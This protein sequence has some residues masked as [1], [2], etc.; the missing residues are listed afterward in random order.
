MTSSIGVQPK[1]LTRR[2]GPVGEI[3]LN[4]P[5]RLN[6]ITVDMW[7]RL[8]EVLAEA[9]ADGA[10]RVLLISGAGGKAFA[11]GADISTIS[12]E[13]GDL[14]AVRNYDKLAGETAEVLYNFPKP[15]IAKISGACVGG[16]LNLAVCCDMRIAA[17]DATFSVPA[18]K[19]GIGYGLGG[20]TRL[21][22]VVGL[23]IAMDLFFTARCVLPEEAL[24]VGLVNRVVASADIDDVV[25]ETASIIC[26]NAPL[27]IAGFKAVARELRKPAASR[28][29]A[30]I[31]RLVEACFTSKD[32]AEGRRALMEKRKPDFSGT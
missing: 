30:G 26:E 2:A 31:S 10:V 29:H 17:A 32:F 4:N 13:G 6:A 5:A 15:T 18:A 28:D 12:A 8:L 9:A 7:G 21:A 24:R 22:E 1:I 25:A 20:V 3:V 19:L 11:G 14:E 23:P 16:G 27:S